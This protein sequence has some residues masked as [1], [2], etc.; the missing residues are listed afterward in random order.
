MITLRGVAMVATATFIYLLAR[1]TQVGWLYLLDA[2]VWG[3]II[4]SLIL[5]FLA[6][7]SLGQTERGPLP[8]KARLDGTR[9]G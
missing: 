7:L 5:P 3:S 1:L 9:G 8:G 4:L 2:M 6:S